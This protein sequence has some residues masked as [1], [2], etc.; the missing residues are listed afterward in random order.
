MDYKIGM[1]NEGFKLV[2]G[3]EFPP[4]GE[5]PETIYE[6]QEISLTCAKNDWAAFQVLICAAEDGTLSL[7]GQPV[8]SCQ[9]NVKDLRLSAS[10]EGGLT[11]D[12]R[13]VALMDDDD[14]LEKADLIMNTGMIY[15]EK[16]KPQTVWVE[17]KIPKTAEKGTYRGKIE[18]FTHRVF[19]AEA[20]IHE[21]SFTIQVR[22]VLLPDVKDFKF[23]LDLWQ[24]P[25]NIARKHEVEYWS[26]RHFEILEGYIKSLGELGQKAATVIVS[27]IPWTGQNCYRVKNYPSDLYEYSMVGVTKKADGT[28]SYD[29]RTMERYIELCLKHGLDREI[30]VFGLINI[31]PGEDGFAT[32]SDYPD[33]VRIRYFDQTDNCYKYMEKAQDIKEYI[34]ALEQY[35]ISGGYID[36]VL[37]VADEPSDMERYRKSL[38]TLK[39]TAPAFRYKTAINHAEF[40]REFKDDIADMVPFLHCVAREWDFLKQVQPAHDG[41]ILWYVCCGPDYPNTFLKSPLAE[42]RLIPVLTYYMG[43][44]GFLRWN[45]TVW[46]QNPRQKISFRAPVWKAGDTNF[47]YPSYGGEVLLTNRYKLLKRGIGDFEL[48]HMLE[49]KGGKDHLIFAKIWALLLKTQQI[50]DFNTVESRKEPKELY[51]IDYKDY[52]QVKEWVLE[53]LE[54]F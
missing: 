27:E 14:S 1:A 52:E 40:I 44:D 31:W 7:N 34:K 24:H 46:P 12:M 29:Y 36:K 48:L 32:P 39:E 8:F 18:C 51:S 35:F 37:V 16:D 28:F 10:V 13:P 17:V 26:D 43:L 38:Q 21:L 5:L 45:Y 4:I 19:Q 3:S 20:K 23:H 2:Y 6:R 30:E 54:E 47:V 53:A 9:G 11:A 49:E 33:G 42:S 41:R 15:L 22:D 50:S 25:S